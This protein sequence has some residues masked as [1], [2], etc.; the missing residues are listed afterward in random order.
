MQPLLGSW[1]GWV[2]AETPLRALQ[3]GND[4]VAC[5]Q[6][7]RWQHIACDPRAGLGNLKQF[8]DSGKVFACVDCSKIKADQEQQQQQQQQQILAGSM[9]P[10]A[11][12]VDPARKLQPGLAHNMQTAQA[13]QHALQAT[14]AVG[15]PPM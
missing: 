3:S 4:W 5:G 9:G 1:L 10:D 14:Q 11:M 8:A 6:C 12:A 2:A 13:Q 7:H 15:Q